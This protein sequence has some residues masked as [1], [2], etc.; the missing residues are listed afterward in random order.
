VV[1]FSC[2]DLLLPPIRPFF[3]SCSVI[4]PDIEASNGVI[5][6]IDRVLLPRG[7]EKKN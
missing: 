1:V 6:L 5:H 4:R 3:F 7:E 2:A